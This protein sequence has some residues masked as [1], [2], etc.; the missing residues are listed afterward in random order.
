ML[1]SKTAALPGRI[2]DGGPTQGFYAPFGVKI[3]DVGEI[4]SV[5]P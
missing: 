1:E 2:W 4:V 5:S 3:S